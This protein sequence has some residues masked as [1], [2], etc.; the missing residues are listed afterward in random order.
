LR[1]VTGAG[2]LNV[3]LSI[4]L[5]PTAMDMLMGGKI[6][7]GYY[8]TDNIGL[9]AVFVYLRT[10]TNAYYEMSMF[11]AFAGVSVRLF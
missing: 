8:F 6:D 1:S 11:N 5:C 4:V 9:T 10:L 3:G 7:G 2:L